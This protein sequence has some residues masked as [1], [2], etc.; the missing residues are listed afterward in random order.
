MVAGITWKPQ[1][2]NSEIGIGIQDIY[3]KFI[4]VTVLFLHVKNRI[5]SAN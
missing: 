1:N 4:I 5:T 3:K 2:K